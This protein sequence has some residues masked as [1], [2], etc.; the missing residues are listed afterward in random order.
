MG[1]DSAELESMEKWLGEDIASKNAFGFSAIN[2]ALSR[3]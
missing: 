2:T 3:D 1:L